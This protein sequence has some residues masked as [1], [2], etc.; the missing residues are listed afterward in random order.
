[1]I[2]V[3][4]VNNHHS[5]IESVDVLQSM[6]S[7]QYQMQMTSVLIPVWQILIVWAMKEVTFV[8]ALVDTLEMA[9]AVVL[10]MKKI[11]R[12]SI[13]VLEWLLLDWP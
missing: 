7:F 6:T 1:M 5:V 8:C 11:R 10:V 4:R 3:S 9:S 13:L 12:Q 2:L